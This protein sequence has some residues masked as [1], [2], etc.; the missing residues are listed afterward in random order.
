MRLAL[1]L[2]NRQLWQAMAAR[3]NA[4][5]VEVFDRLTIGDAI[6]RAWVV[7][8]A[9]HVL[10]EDYNVSGLHS[11]HTRLI[12]DRETLAKVIVAIKVRRKFMTVKLQ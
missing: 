4:P 5:A 11:D 12:D 3:C 2:R 10:W 9:R 7:W 1:T 6:V 8:H